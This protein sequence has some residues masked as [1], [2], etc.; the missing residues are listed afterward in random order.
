MGVGLYLIEKL[1]RG[2]MWRMAECTQLDVVDKQMERVESEVEEPS[3][4][5]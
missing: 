5:A 4:V 2:E 1:E 3:G